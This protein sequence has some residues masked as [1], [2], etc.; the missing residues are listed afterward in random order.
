MSV[1]EYTI[2]ILGP[3][4]LGLSLLLWAT[5]A[6]DGWVVVLILMTK[7]EINFKFQR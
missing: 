1:K 3:V 4:Q 5:G 2:N 7:I 6:V